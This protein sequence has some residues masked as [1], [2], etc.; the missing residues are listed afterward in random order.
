MSYCSEG[1][2]RTR[3]SSQ[4]N[5]F[6]KNKN[7]F[8]PFC[9]K[10]WNNLSVELQ[11]IKSAVQFKTKILSFIRS[12]EI[13]I[14]N[15]HDTNDIKLLDRLRLAFNHLNE[16][17]FL[18]SFRATINPL[19]SCSL[20]PE[21][22]HHSVLPR[23]LSSDLRTELPNNICA[24]NTVLKYLYHENLLNILLCRS[25]DFSLNKK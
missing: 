21:T 8:F 7:L 20:E 9:I 12:K 4:N 10:D 13:S 15:I 24:L 25:K 19:C 14:F 23:N 5:L 16:H 11:E 3:S 22:T 6:Y 18:H 17:K 1:V 2:Y